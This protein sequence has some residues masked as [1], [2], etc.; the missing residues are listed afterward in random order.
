[1]VLLAFVAGAPSAPRH[2]GARPAAWP[3][4]P[5]ARHLVCCRS[6]GDYVLPGPFSRTAGW[7]EPGSVGPWTCSSATSRSPSCTTRYKLPP[8]EPAARSCSAGEVGIGK[9]AL[10]RH[11]ANR[12]GQVWL[13]ACDP[14]ETPRGLTTLSIAIAAL[15]DVA[16]QDDPNQFDRLGKKYLINDTETKGSDRRARLVRGEEDAAVYWIVL[17]ERRP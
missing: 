1:M 10:V 11:I 2:S 12:A 9:I 15:R 5:C 17:I 6:T 8:R 16:A 3:G 7:P 14:L 13:G 4:S